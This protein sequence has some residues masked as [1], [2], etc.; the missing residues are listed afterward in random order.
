M[1]ATNRK[2][3][4]SSAK[5]LEK[6]F[7]DE[8]TI[9]FCVSLVFYFSRMFSALYNLINDCDESMN[10]WE[11]MHYILYGFGL[12]TWEYR[13]QLFRNLNVSLISENHILTFQS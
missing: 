1:K 5:I 13:F 2:S 10:Y 6:Y 8:N 12:Q 7:Q 9:L 11:P 3:A 4:K